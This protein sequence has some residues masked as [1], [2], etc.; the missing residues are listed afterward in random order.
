MQF[1]LAIELTLMLLF[2]VRVSIRNI[3]HELRRKPI[4][5]DETD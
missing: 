5:N 1:F 2:A 4:C 3:E